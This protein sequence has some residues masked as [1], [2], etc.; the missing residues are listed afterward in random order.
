MSEGIPIDNVTLSK[1]MNTPTIIRIVT[2]LDITS[3]TILELLE[4][5]LNMSDIIFAMANGVV[6][7]DNTAIGSSEHNITEIVLNANL[8]FAFVRRKVRLTR[9]GLYV[10]ESIK[11][12]QFTRA[13]G[14]YHSYSPDTDPRHASTV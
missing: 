5:D 7:Y 10:L 3:L 14:D 11:G 1:L 12:N 8:Y 4:Y 13:G 9:L 6:T 2:I